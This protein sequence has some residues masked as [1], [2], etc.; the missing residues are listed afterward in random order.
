[1]D[2]LLWQSA[3]AGECDSLSDQNGNV[4]SPTQGS[5]GFVY[6]DISVT[7]PASG[8][9]DIS[10]IQVSL[11]SHGATFSEDDQAAQSAGLGTLPNPIQP[12]RGDSIGSDQIYVFDVSDTNP[13]GDQL[14]IKDSNNGQTGVYPVTAGMVEPPNQPSQ[15]NL[16]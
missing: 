12:T 2:G 3:E 5:G 1:V 7:N 13:A 6:A 15:Q 8:P 10:N 16:C 9:V 14:V 11:R 4:V